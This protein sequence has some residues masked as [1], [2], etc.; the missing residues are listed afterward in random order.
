MLIVGVPRSG[1]SWVAHELYKVGWFK[2]WTAP[3]NEFNP[4]GYYE[5]LPFKNTFVKPFMHDPFGLTDFR[6]AES[7]ITSDA[8]YNMLRE[9]GWA[10]Q[11]WFIKEPKM[12]FMWRSIADALPGVPWVKVR[13]KEE[14]IRDCMKRTAFLDNC[15]HDEFYRA[16]RERMD[17][18]D[19]VE[20]WPF[21]GGIPA[22]IDS[23]K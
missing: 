17:E 5:N 6:D 2:G 11:R 14:D 20:V 3:G 16:Y 8:F 18:I 22:F 12:L 13:R 21:E 23:L 7:D 9:Q 10:G 4:K 15:D 19:G 1:T